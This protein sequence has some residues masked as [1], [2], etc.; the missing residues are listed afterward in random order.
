MK[1]FTIWRV[2]A[3]GGKHVLGYRGEESDVERQG[4]KD[5]EEKK[6]GNG[7]ERKNYREWRITERNAQRK[8]ENR[9][10]VRMS[11]C[12]GERERKR[13]EEMETRRKE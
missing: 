1:I 9:K 3:R 7:R 10:E 11:R 8:Q 2:G 5:G 4:G 6:R 13:E 12:M